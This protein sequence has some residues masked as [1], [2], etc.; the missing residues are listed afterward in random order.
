MKGLGDALVIFGVLLVLY[1]I[2]G[3]FFIGGPEIGLGFAKLKAIS[4]VTAATFC[5]LLGIAFKL[6]DQ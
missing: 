1:S 4:G 6:W 2:I 3:R 5:V